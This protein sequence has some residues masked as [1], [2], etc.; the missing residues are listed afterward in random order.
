MARENYSAAAFQAVLD[1]ATEQA[2]KA[3]QSERDK[4]LPEAFL[5]YKQSLQTY[6]MVIEE[7][8]FSC[9][10]FQE[11]NE[12]LLLSLDSTDKLRKHAKAGKERAKQPEDESDFEPTA[13]MNRLPGVLCLSPDQPVRWGDVIGHETP[14]FVLKL[15]VLDRCPI[16]HP[17]MFTGKRRTLKSILLFGPSG[18]GKTY[19]TKALMGAAKDW[20]C[21]DVNMAKLI[22]DAPEG[23]ED[24]Y[25]KS[26]FKAARLA[27]WAILVL[28]DIHLL[29]K[30][31][32]KPTEELR[33]QR[34]RQSVASEIQFLNDTITAEIT[35]CVAT[36]SS[37]RMIEPSFAGVFKKFVY[38]PLPR[39]PE[40]LRIFK[41]LV[42]RDPC[43]VTDDEWTTVVNKTQGYSGADILTVVMHTYK[44]SDRPLTFNELSL[45]TDLYRPRNTADDIQACLRFKH[46]HASTAP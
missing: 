34:I 2:S 11:R 14:K 18:C 7:L 8:L 28:Q 21:M 37:P 33:N 31:S 38:V 45:A 23:A 12:E 17:I 4:K 27:A 39:A 20:V 43:E 42:G 25:I 32:D 46:Q 40:R 16:K 6:L 22:R 35:L 44:D 36:T 30:P 3:E 41:Q 1:K 9:N 13:N 19:L 24:L 10:R 26:L 29:F 15:A 5:M